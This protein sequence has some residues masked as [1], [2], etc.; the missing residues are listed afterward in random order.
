MFMRLRTMGI[1]ESTRECDMKIRSDSGA[2]QVLTLRMY[3]TLKDC[4]A[5]DLRG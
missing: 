3:V 1:Y 5:G 4:G 2:Q